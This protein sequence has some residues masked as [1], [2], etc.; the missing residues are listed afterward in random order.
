MFSDK[1][2]GGDFSVSRLS[3]VHP[4]SCGDEGY[5]AWCIPA[6]CQTIL[7]HFSKFITSEETTMGGDPTLVVQTMCPQFRAFA[8]VM[9]GDLKF[10]F[11]NA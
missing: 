6:W 11:S 10:F 3:V 2:A 7:S 5:Q 8:A 1:P 9:V 4:T